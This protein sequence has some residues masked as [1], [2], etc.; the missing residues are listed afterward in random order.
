[1]GVNA[2]MVGQA[3]F[4]ETVF[5]AYFLNTP[6]P[7]LDILVGRELTRT[8]PNVD[9]P[10]M[11]DQPIRL[12]ASKWMDAAVSLIV[13]HNTYEGLLFTGPRVSTEATFKSFFQSLKPSLPPCFLC[14]QARAGAEIGRPYP[15]VV[16]VEASLQRYS[17]SSLISYVCP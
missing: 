2:A 7:S 6:P 10:F 15:G 3:A 11:L 1:M 4:A 8:G 14:Q 5:G 13:A 9:G 12:M 16:Y 17:H